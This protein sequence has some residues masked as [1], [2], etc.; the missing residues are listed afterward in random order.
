[1]IESIIA[2]HRPVEGSKRA[3]YFISTPNHYPLVRYDGTT[4]STAA[5][6]GDSPAWIGVTGGGWTRNILGIGG[7]L[8]AVQDNTGT[9]TLQLANLRGDI[10]ATVPDDTAATAIASYAESSEFGTP[11]FAS[12]AYAR[13]GWLGGKQRSRDTLGGLTLM[14]VRLY[15]PYTGRFLSTDPIFGG[16]AKE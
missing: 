12:T 11:Y 6:L 8:A 7:D 10:V 3:S 1:M 2:G 4:G 5:E 16:N 9:V 15:N 13:Y 14:G